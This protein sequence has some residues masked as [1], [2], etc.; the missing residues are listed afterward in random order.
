[1]EPQRRPGGRSARVR[2]AVLDATTAELAEHGYLGLNVDAVAQ[3]AGVHKT[4]VYRRWR[5]PEGLVADALERALGQPWP[6]PDT[7]SLTGDLRALTALLRDSFDDPDAAPLATAFIIAGMHDPHAAAALRAFYEARHRD[8]A[9]IVERAVARGELD[10]GVDGVE[11]VRTA[12]APIFHRLFITHEP[13]TAED[14]RRA[15][16]A[17]AVLAS[18]STGDRPHTDPRKPHAP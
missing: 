17:A 2:E 13:V 9:V 1:M 5:G 6:I 12:V 16:D 14:A 3:R 11:T 4:T 7:G 18:M 8:A 10:P 15:A